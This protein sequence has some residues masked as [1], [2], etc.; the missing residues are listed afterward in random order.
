MGANT[1]LLVIVTAT[2]T[3]ILALVLAGVVYKTRAPKWRELARDQDEEDALQLSR[4][5][6]LGEESAAKA[7]AAQVDIEIKP[8]RASSLNRV[9]DGTHQGK[10]L[11]TKDMS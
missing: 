2:A 8:V 6:L 3:L 7:H 10:R 5:E 9:K 11:R 1:T 4:E